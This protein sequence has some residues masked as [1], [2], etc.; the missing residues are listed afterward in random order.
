VVAYTLHD[1]DRD[2]IA[3]MFHNDGSFFRR[4]NVARSFAEEHSANV[5][6]ADDGRFAIAYQIDS[7]HGLNSDIRLRRY[8]A[9]GAL[10][11]ASVIT[12][13]RHRLETNPA[14]ALDN[15][16][17]AVVAYEV[18]IGGDWDIH[19]RRVSNRG[20]VGPV[21]AVQDIIGSDELGP[22]IALDR[23]T[24]RFA[25]SY[26]YAE[27]GSTGVEVAEFQANGQ[28]IQTIDL[29]TNR[30]FPAISIDGFGFYFVTYTSFDRDDDPEAG[31]FGHFGEL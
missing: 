21:F 3:H 7:R 11:G 6:R 5:A 22:S 28:R 27:G 31:I 2:V 14:V 25:V 16:G 8:N 30:D 17:S 26:E 24:G 19:A 20:R 23:T 15:S 12:G 9:R 4:I 29:G 10:L 1:P 18:R 13:T